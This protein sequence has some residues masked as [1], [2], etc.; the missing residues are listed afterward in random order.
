[1]IFLL[2]MTLFLNGKKLETK[3][4]EKVFTF[5][6]PLEGK[7]NIRVTSGEY[8]D[9][10]QFRH[11]DTPNPAYCLKDSGDKGANWTK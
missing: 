3:Y 11:V 5:R 1:M 6:V 9:E 10:A 7:A 8:S 4:G 2:S